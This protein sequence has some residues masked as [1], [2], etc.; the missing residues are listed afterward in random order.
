MLSWDHWH[1]GCKGCTASFT[2]FKWVSLKSTMYQLRYQSYQWGS[3]E[4]QVRFTD[5]QEFQQ[6]S[7]TFSEV[8]KI[9]LTSTIIIYQSLA[10]LPFTA[11]TLKR[12]APTN[13]GLAQ[14][15]QPSR[16]R[17]EARPDWAGP[18][19]PGWKRLARGSAGAL[20]PAPCPQLKG[21]PINTRPRARP[22]SRSIFWSQSSRWGSEVKVANAF[23][24]KVQNLHDLWGPNG[25]RSNRLVP[26]PNLGPAATNRD[27]RLYP[28]VCFSCIVT[29]LHLSVI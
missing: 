28:E 7:V 16:P 11:L 19:R 27:L 5:N 8:H 29:N 2:M 18:P 15:A 24:V 3:Q 12:G 22:D 10:Q 4:Y 25:S 6:I 20:T 9:D 26:G 13:K 23:K 21:R 14:G 1:N 17:N